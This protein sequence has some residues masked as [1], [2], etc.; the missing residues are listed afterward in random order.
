MSAFFRRFFCMLRDGGETLT[1]GKPTS[2]QIAKRLRTGDRSQDVGFPRPKKPAVAAETMRPRSLP[3]NVRDDGSKRDPI[4]EASY[5]VGSKVAEVFRHVMIEGDRIP[6][7]IEAPEYGDAPVTI[8]ASAIAKDGEVPPPKTTYDRK[9]SRSGPSIKSQ[10][11]SAAVVRDLNDRKIRLSV[12][13][14][15]DVLRILQ[16][17]S[18]EPVENDPVQILSPAG[19]ITELGEN[20]VITRSSRRSLFESTSWKERTVGE[21][22][23][24][25]DCSVRLSNCITANPDFFFGW[26]VGRALAN[27]S[28]FASALRH[29]QNLGRKTANEVLEA[30]EAFALHPRFKEDEPVVVDPLSGFVPSKLKRSLSDLFG[31]KHV[32][33]RLA[34]V[35]A[36]GGL[37]GL[38]IRDF[39]LNA[40]AV[41]A[42][43]MACSN[44]GQKTTEEAIELLAAYV[45][46]L[47]RPDIE[48]K[49]LTRNDQVGSELMSTDEWIRQ[50]LRSLP[51][52]HIEVLQSRYGL[53]GGVKQTLQEI[54]GRVHVTRERVR[55]VEAKALKQLRTEERSRAAF[56]RHLDE[57]R[58][59]QWA[60]LF[61]SQSPLPENKISERFRRLDPWFLLAIDVVF[62]NG[63]DGYLQANAHRTMAGWFKSADEATDRQKVED[64]LSNVLSDYKTPMPLDTLEK[65]APSVMDFISGRG[66]HW[67]VHDGYLSTGYVGA[68]ARRTARMHAIARRI[69]QSSIFDIGTLIN[70]YR[71]EF[72]D[73]DCSSRMFDMQANEAPHLFAPI[74]DG[75]WLC[76]DHDP[77]Q[78]VPLPAPPF[79]RRRVEGTHFAEGS[80]GDQMVKQLVE[81]GPQ[82]LIDLRRTIADNV[83]G[84]FSESSVGAILITNPCFQRVAPGIFGL[85]TGAP[86]VPG[87]LD[88]YLLEDRH[89][90]FY[91][92]A[93]HS[94]AP[95][96]YYPMW[97]AAYEMRLAL[98]SQQNAPR[99]LYHSLMSVIEPKS[100]PAA[101]EIIAG[102]EALRARDGRWA[103]R[104]SPAPYIR[105]SFPGPGAVFFLY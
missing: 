48:H 2:E 96:D 8:E 22:I 50:E 83:E 69:A 10:S 92:H 42:R 73:D 29:V 36:S 7:P 26:D 3:E 79:E 87:C 45:E 9:E 35:A 72:S 54:A 85:Q 51:P 102:F 53:D 13:E 32:S 40:D 60:I 23:L 80:L 52:K 11:D 24:E 20:E 57:K 77:G 62:E 31:S 91:C 44:S 70:K 65:I 89:C 18:R 103:D 82:R 99:D 104:R 78:V 21:V 15:P 1:E 55:Q 33:V 14:L 47:G 5:K 46:F 86:V 66:G 59:A 19:L 68:K 49:A 100:W 101:A 84:S 64:L 38:T 6:E 98:W 94:G 105:T 41:R 97:G 16:L 71:S 75:I 34:N 76:L 12:A 43:L 17:D 30:L 4:E 56:I 67:A 63:V 25:E 58:D 74:F 61:Q 27:R 81:F 95:Q 39:V 93:R 28:E 88:A 90:R 37:D